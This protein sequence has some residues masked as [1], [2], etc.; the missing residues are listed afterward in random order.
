MILMLLLSEL[1]LIV[2]RWVVDVFLLQLDDLSESAGN[3]RVQINV[4]P[5]IGCLVSDIILDIVTYLPRTSA[6]SATSP[7]STGEYGGGPSLPGDCARVS[8][9]PMVLSLLPE[10]SGKETSETG[11][12][13]ALS[14]EADE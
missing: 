6:D 9:L 10:A 13:N 2:G 7:P 8:G 14:H 12:D 1:L 5:S 4:N 11:R 3:P